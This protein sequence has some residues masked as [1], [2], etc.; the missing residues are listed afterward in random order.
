MVCLYMCVNVCAPKMN[1]YIY[2]CMNECGSQRP[3]VCHSSGALNAVHR[4]SFLLAPGITEWTILE[5]Q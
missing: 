1:F 4:D 5:V 2:V 3:P